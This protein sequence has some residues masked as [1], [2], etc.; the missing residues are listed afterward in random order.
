MKHSDEYLHYVL[1]A[2]IARNLFG[3]ENY[4][5][6]MRDIDEPYLRAMQELHGVK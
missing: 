1:K 6:V 2:T 3:V 5:M 4:Y